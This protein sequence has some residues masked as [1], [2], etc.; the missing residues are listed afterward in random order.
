MGAWL[1][2]VMDGSASAP[3]VRFCVGDTVDV[4]NPF[5]LP[6]VEEVRHTGMVERITERDGLPTLYWVSG[7]A[8]ARTTP[9]L[10]LVRRAR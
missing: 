9:V 1:S 4:L 6:A 7:L 8:A 5:R 3:A 2:S 10:R